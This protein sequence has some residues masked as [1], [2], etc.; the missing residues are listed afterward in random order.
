MLD[1]A[2]E[3]QTPQEEAEFHGDCGRIDQIFTLRRLLEYPI[4][5]QNPTIIV[6]LDICATFDS[7][8]RSAL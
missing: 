8:D 6:L 7:A 3:G 1:N 2:S 5:F 4:T